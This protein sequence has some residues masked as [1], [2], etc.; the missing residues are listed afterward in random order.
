MII[1]NSDKYKFG[2][3]NTLD[4]DFIKTF[5]RKMPDGSGKHIMKFNLPAYTGIIMK[6]I[7]NNFVHDKKCDIKKP[8]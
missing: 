1:M 8:T 7:P 4:T 2:G 5:P 6:K 3:T